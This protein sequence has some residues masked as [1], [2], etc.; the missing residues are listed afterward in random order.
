MKKDEE[1]KKEEI[2]FGRLGT[3]Y[4]QAEAK[5]ENITARNVQ[6]S[7]NQ[8]VQVKG[9]RLLGEVLSKGKFRQMFDHVQQL[10]LFK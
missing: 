6:V 8:V 7:F 9:I 5:I 2:W 4:E 10:N 1:I 3:A